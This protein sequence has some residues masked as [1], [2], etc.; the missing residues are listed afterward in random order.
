[1]LYISFCEIASLLFIRTRSSIKYLPKLLTLANLIF[2][3]YVQSYMYPAMV[4]A[5]ICLGDFTMVMF[6]YF[7]YR[8]EIPAVKDWNPCGT[9][10]P[11]EQNPRCGYQHI[12]ASPEYAHGFDIFSMFYRLRFIET[13]PHDSQQVYMRLQADDVAAH[14]LGVNFSAR[15]IDVVQPI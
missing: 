15:P 2:L 11:S 4:N 10:T 8:Y 13:F 3:V 9:Y 5:L 1:M 14:T 12:M 6:A 7:I